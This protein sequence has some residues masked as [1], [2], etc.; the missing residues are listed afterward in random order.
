MKNSLKLIFM[1]AIVGIIVSSCAFQQ[2]MM[3]QP[4]HYGYPAQN[5]AIDAVRAAG[6]I[7]ANYQRNLVHQHQINNAYL[8]S[9]SGAASHRINMSR[10]GIR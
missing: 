8:N 9:A 6:Y 5:T 7:N 1:S 3:Q 4:Y 2:P 10:L